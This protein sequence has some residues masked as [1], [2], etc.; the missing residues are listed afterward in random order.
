VLSILL[1]IFATNRRALGIANSQLQIRG[2]PRL[3]NGYRFQT[4][5]KSFSA[6]MK[7][8]TGISTTAHSKAYLAVAWRTRHQLQDHERLS[9]SCLATVR[10]RGRLAQIFGECSGACTSRFALL[11]QY[12]DI[13]SRPVVHTRYNSSRKRRQLDQPAAISTH[14]K[15]P[16]LLLSR[17]EAW[18]STARHGGH[19][20]SYLYRGVLSGAAHNRAADVR[21]LTSFIGPYFLV[22][23]FYLV[24]SSVIKLRCQ[25]L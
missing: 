22:L 5:V 14:R 21:P 12:Q 16:P 18:L 2:I 9:F 8:R 1:G 10:R 7:L 6:F 11:R 17:A 13:T 23:T 3:W 4:V 24:V 19:G 15:D 20:K 25:S